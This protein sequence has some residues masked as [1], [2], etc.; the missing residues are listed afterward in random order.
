MPYTSIPKPPDS[1]ELED[2]SAS[3]QYWSLREKETQRNQLRNS[4]Y[5]AGPPMIPPRN[6]FPQ[7]LHD[8]VIT[9]RHEYCG[10]ALQ[11]F[12]PH[13]Q[14]V[15]HQDG[16]NYWHQQ[17]DT[18]GYHSTPDSNPY[19]PQPQ[20][21]ARDTA[22]YYGQPAEI[23]QG[24]FQENPEP[25]SGFPL[26]M[27]DPSDYISRNTLVH[28]PSEMNPCYPTSY[29][30]SDFMT[31]PDPRDYQM[32]L[33]DINPYDPT[34]LP[35]AHEGLLK[36]L[37]S[38]RDISQ[39][40]EYLNCFSG[41]EIVSAI[42]DVLE[43]AQR[44]TAMKI[45]RLLQEN[46]VFQHVSSN[47]RILMDNDQEFYR[48]CILD[49]KDEPKAD[50]VETSDSGQPVEDQPVPEDNQ[51]QVASSLAEQ[52]VNDQPSD[53]P[54]YTT[55][56]VSR[57]PTE[58]IR[59]SANEYESLWIASIPEG[60]MDTLSDKERSRQI[61]I[62]EIIYT[63]EEYLR[64]L[65]LY[66]TL[67]IEPLRAS[68]VFGSDKA[69]NF[70]QDVFV[71]YRELQQIHEEIIAILKE[72]QSL[73]A[74]I[75]MIGDI[76]VQFVERF[77]PYV[78]FS[79]GSVNSGRVLKNERAQS[80]ALDGFL[81]DL[82]LDDKDRQYIRDG[83]LKRSIGQSLRLILFDHMLLLAKDKK[84]FTNSNITYRAY[85]K[86]IPLELL[87]IQIHSDNSD[88]AGEES[89]KNSYCFTITDLSKCGGSYTL[90]ASSFA[91]RKQWVDKIQEQKAKRMYKQPRIFEIAR[92]SDHGFVLEKTALCSCV[93]STREGRR[94]IAIGTMDGLF[95]GFEGD[96][97]SFRKVLDHPRIHQVEVLEEI[98]MV[99][100]LQDKL[101]LTYSIDILDSPESWANRQSQK[102]AS[103][104]S[105]FGTGRCD[106]KLLVVLM[107]LKGMKSFFKVLEPV[108]L[109]EN[110]KIKGKLLC[111]RNGFAL[112]LFKEFYIGAE[113]FSVQFL[114]KKL[115][116]V[117]PKGFEIIN[118][119]ALHL[120]KSIPDL[121]DEAQFGFINRREECKPLA[122]FPLDT[123]EFLLCYNEFAIHLD[124]LGRRTRPNL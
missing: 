22:I 104:V 98:R 11:P 31:I 65:K 123:E 117:C 111:Q 119:E 30:H 84:A 23:P 112:R 67:F 43:V 25:H 92:V 21:P 37:Q 113:S 61:A 10:V 88:A 52:A 26:R 68:R 45:G 73:N 89:T 20:Y 93:Y 66:D 18:Y 69:E 83:L 6:N 87:T 4:H 33:A 17:S 64:D 48:L 120:N 60:I 14:Y 121:S 50:L 108:S 42:C 3:T 74:I 9:P 100:V 28:F 78:H 57:K 39:S 36:T 85:V 99:V 102:L 56:N 96:P 124:K 53:T 106:G 19:F 118:L 105:Y 41:H 62:F 5:R 15:N 116:V 40:N 38:K 86:P 95:S 110:P 32:S 59:Q 34:L 75:E 114:T 49:A 71:N 90:I 8:Q 107:K 55:T 109:R 103:Q 2:L 27:P 101:L 77:E 58:L 76:I 16:Y 7:Q 72:R 80:S 122:M 44:E 81:E 51:E 79:T 47:N 91:E 115:Y 1:S 54:L 46:E 29:E 24:R 94:K 70:I 63:E 97:A 35:I 13:S 82:K 12:Q